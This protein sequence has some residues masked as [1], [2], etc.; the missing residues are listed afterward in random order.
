VYTGR[1]WEPISGGDTL[2][3]PATLPEAPPPG[4]YYLRQ[5]YQIMAVHNSELF[6]TN[7]PLQAGS[8]VS[9][10]SAGPADT[11][12]LRGAVDTYEV[13][14]A[15]T[16]VTANRLD[17]TGTE[18]PAEVNAVYLQIPDGLP[19]RVHALSAPGARPIKKPS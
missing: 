4:R 10:V 11:R 6:S 2:D 8:P 5:S 13:I 3:M 9:L 16:D 19:E 14:S 17:S 18:Y 7:D 1:G 15:A 12:L